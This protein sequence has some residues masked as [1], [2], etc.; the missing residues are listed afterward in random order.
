MYRKSYTPCNEE[1]RCYYEDWHFDSEI[2]KKVKCCRVLDS[3]NPYKSGKCMF[4]KPTKNSYSGSYDGEAYSPEM[5]KKIE[6]NEKAYK[7]AHGIIGK[8]G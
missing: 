2:D 3:K 8:R 7:T 1:R 5:L 4:F 6:E